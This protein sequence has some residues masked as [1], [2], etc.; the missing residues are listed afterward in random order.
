M[1]KKTQKNKTNFEKVSTNRKPV[2]LKKGFYKNK[3]TGHPSLVFAQQ[4]KKVKSIGFTHQIN[5]A[6]P[7]INLK[8]NID[9]KD[10]STTY[11]L[12][13]I[14][15][16]LVEN[17][18]ENAKYKDYRIHQDDKETIKNIIKKGSK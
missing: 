2:K 8:H 1:P 18:K 7:K 12:T 13:N 15:K 9:P 17:Y 14:Q 6:E 3:K 10:P 16:E 11:A 4:Y 5:Y